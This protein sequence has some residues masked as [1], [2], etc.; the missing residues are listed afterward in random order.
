MQKKYPG[1]LLIFIG[2]IFLYLSFKFPMSPILAL[3]LLIGSIILN[4]AGTIVLVKMFISLQKQSEM[5]GKETT[6][7]H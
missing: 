5:K 2:L 7:K 1:F 6:K 4:I 3:L